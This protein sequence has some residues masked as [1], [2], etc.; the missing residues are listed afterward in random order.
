MASEWVM[1]LAIIGIGVVTIA[2]VTSTFDLM[3]LNVADSTVEVGLQEVASI[4]AKEMKKV[5]ELGLSTDPLTE[6]TITQILNLP[7]DIAG[8]QYVIEFSR[9]IGSNNLYLKAIDLE[10]PLEIIYETTLPRDIILESPTGEL[11]PP[12]RSANYQHFLS[13][14]RTGGSSVYRI[15]IG[16]TS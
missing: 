5:Y 11:D 2:G 12:I 13:F 8:R 6:V 14:Q 9:R 10:S 1:Y 4:V 16:Y 3:N 15:I 7:T